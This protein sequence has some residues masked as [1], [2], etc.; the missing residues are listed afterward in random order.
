[1]AI[2]GDEIHDYVIKQINQRQNAHASGQNGDERR[3]HEEVREK[4]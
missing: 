4:N 3:K 2:V 1:M